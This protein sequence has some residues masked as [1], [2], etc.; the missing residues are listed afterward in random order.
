M[1]GKQTV[2]S[3]DGLYIESLRTYVYRATASQPEDASAVSSASLGLQLTPLSVP[4]HGMEWV[5]GKC[6]LQ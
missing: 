4:P 1:D 6:I 2:V 5:H 3:M